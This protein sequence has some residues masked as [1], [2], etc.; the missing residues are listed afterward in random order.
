VKGV[1][2]GVVT[3]A[4]GTIVNA[5]QNALTPLGVYLIDESP[6]S[7]IV[8]NLMWLMTRLKNGSLQLRS[9]NFSCGQDVPL[10]AERR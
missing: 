1:G 3:G 10:V 7:P 9:C 6:D 2:K 8:L 5:M 4:P